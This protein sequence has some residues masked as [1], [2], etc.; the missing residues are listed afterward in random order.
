MDI[1][2]ATN[3]IRERSAFSSRISSRDSSTHSLTSLCPYYERIEIQN[4]LLDEHIQNPVDNSQLSYTSNGKKAGNLV[5]K[6]TAN[7]S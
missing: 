7:S 1:E 4:N 3:I 5:R 6:T 2:I